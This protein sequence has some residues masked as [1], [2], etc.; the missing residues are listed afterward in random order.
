LAHQ[1][2]KKNG[3]CEHAVVNLNYITLNTLIPHD[4]IAV[5]NNKLTN[6]MFIDAFIH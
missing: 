6:K 5:I 2:R 3:F 4:R 1:G